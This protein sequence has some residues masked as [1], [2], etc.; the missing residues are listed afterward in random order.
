MVEDVIADCMEL[1][2]P[3]AVK[4]LDMA[5]TIHPDVPRWIIGDYAR[6]RQV[7]MNLL[8]NGLKFTSSGFVH[9]S[10][11]LEKVLTEPADSLVLK[12]MIQWVYQKDAMLLN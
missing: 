8:G 12:F 4:K 11:S 5:Y 6:V 2:L 3:I 10:C 7:L 9:V 1:L